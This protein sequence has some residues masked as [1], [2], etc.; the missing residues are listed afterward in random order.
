MTEF[1]LETIENANLI[2]AGLDGVDIFVGINALCTA[3]HKVADYCDG[4][5]D[6][7]EIADALRK[8]ADMIEFDGSGGVLQ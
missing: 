1:E 4:A 6:K 7:K 2:L 3:T 8:L 5:Y